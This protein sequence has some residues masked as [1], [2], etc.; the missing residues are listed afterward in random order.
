[1]RADAEWDAGDMGCGELVLELRFRVRPLAPGQI[2]KRTARDPGAPE[3]LPAWCRLT[4]HSLERAEHPIYWI[5]RK[6]D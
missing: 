6:E 3:D 2:F 4:G 5:R 1:M